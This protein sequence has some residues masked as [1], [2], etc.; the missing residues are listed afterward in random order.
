MKNIH[1]GY[2]EEVMFMGKILEGVIFG[3]SII[4]IVQIQH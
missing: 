1:F 2:T 3:Q 4:I